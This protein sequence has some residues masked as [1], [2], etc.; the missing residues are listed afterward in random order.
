MDPKPEDQRSGLEAV[1]VLAEP[2]RRALYEFVVARRGWISREQAADAV[3]LGRGVTSHHL[4]RLAAEGLLDVDYR[5]VNERRGPGAGRPAKVYRRSKTEVAVNLPPRDYELAGELLAEA[6]ERS[7]RDAVPIGE[8]IDRAARAMGRSIGAEAKRRLGR[9]SGIGR[10]REQLLV[11]LEARGFEPELV[12][13]DEVVLHNCPFHQLA[14]SHTELICG[15]NLSLLSSVVE[16]V[17][18]TGWCAR[19]RP[20][21]GYCCVRLQDEALAP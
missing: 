11:T 13:A 14:Q 12:G 21:D 3:G 9:R 4:D 5:R 16:Q 15:M 17:P 6:A 20:H 1:G 18:N 10:A 2:N 19:L 7:E 8:A